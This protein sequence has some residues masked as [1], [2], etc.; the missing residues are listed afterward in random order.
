MKEMKCILFY[1]SAVIAGKK[2]HM[3][4]IGSDKSH[5]S[6]KGSPNRKNILYPY[7][8]FPENTRKL[9][10]RNSWTVGIFTAIRRKGG[11]LP[12]K[13][14]QIVNLQGSAQMQPSVLLFFESAFCSDR[15]LEA[16]PSQIS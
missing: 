11:C 3:I 9:G 1:M 8:P 14:T 15:L 16:H 6:F 4:S 7:R 12:T 10:G 5:S 2:N 13:M